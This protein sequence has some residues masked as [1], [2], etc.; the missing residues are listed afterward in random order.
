MRRDHPGGVNVYVCGDRDVAGRLGRL[1]GRLAA[2]VRSN[3]RGSFCLFARRDLRLA[4]Y[5]AVLGLR[6]RRLGLVLGRAFLAFAADGEHA[7]CGNQN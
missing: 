1:F 6:C 2:S 3:R 4:R 5:L 7:Q